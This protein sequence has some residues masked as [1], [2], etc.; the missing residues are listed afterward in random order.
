MIET[1]HC[2][3]TEWPRMS[4]LAKFVFVQ[5]DNCTSENKNRYLFAYFGSLVA[6]ELFRDVPVLSLPVRQ[7]MKT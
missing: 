3:L 1:V 7:R 4:S 2:L 5:M 6:W